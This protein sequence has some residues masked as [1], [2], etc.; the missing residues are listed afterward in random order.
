MHTGMKKS[1]I[2]YAAAFALLGLSTTSCQK[3]D[4]DPE[5]LRSFTA[6]IDQDSKT[7]LDDD[8]LGVIWDNSDEIMVSVADNGSNRGKRHIFKIGSISSNNVATFHASGNTHNNTYSDQNNIKGTKF[9]LLYPATSAYVNTTD[10][11]MKL[12]I[13]K[14]QKYSEHSMIGSPMY[15]EHTVNS[16][17]NIYGNNGETTTLKFKNLCSQLRLNLQGNYTIKSIVVTCTEPD[18]TYL[19]GVFDIFDAQEGPASNLVTVWEAR[20]IDMPQSAIGMSKS[21]ALDCGSGVDISTAKDFN[22]YMPVGRY[23]ISITAYTPDGSS[24]T[25]N[26]TQAINFDRDHVK[27]LTTTFTPNNHQSQII[28]HSGIFAINA[29]DHVYLSPSNLMNTAGPDTYYDES[30]RFGPQPY[31]MHGEYSNGQTV[32]N[33]FSWSTTDANDNFGMMVG[34]HEQQSRFR[35]DFL[36]WGV[37][38]QLGSDGQTTYPSMYG[39]TLTADQWRYMLGLS[40]DRVSVHME[41]GSS[42]YGYCYILPEPGFRFYANNKWWTR[43]HFVNG[44]IPE[45]NVVPTNEQLNYSGV[46]NTVNALYRNGNVSDGILYS[47]DKGLYDCRV[48]VDGQNW[49]SGIPC[50]VIYPDDMPVAKQLHDYEYFYNNNS[51]ALTQARYEE[52][53]SLGC[54]FLP[55][56]GE[57]EGRAGSTTSAM[58]LHE[59]FYWSST[60]NGQDAAY[61][62]YLTQGNT[63]ISVSVTSGS[64]GN[65]RC[66]RLASHAPADSRHTGNSSK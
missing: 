47:L 29:T 19:S 7:H 33:R 34:G 58:V 59:G 27:K 40:G 37:N 45:N 3:E 23:K 21:I 53:K 5:L 24:A 57:G 65:G 28:P 8:G 51:Y 20:T 14:I 32:W 15:A 43:Y 22:I 6:V 1:N 17:N 52:L 60:P 63:Q 39:F 25:L 11:S 42:C 61:Y 31:D 2:V 50:I 56:V 35:G 9:N 46:P 36:D 12:S 13:P 18:N 62:V 30:W 4:S 64:R 26:A 55:L 54:A 49:Y 44:I 10:G 66:V 16:S 48:K 38:A 41:P